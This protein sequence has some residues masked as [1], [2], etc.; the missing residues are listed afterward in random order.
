MFRFGKPWGAGIK[1]YQDGKE[2]IGYWDNDAFIDSMPTEQ[3]FQTFNE[4]LKTDFETFE[5]KKLAVS[6]MSK[7][8]TMGIDDDAGMENLKINQLD[9]EVIQMEESLAK[10]NFLINLK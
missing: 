9:E 7:K 3:Q 10:A 6:L 8:K 4:I 1:I 5:F 2:R